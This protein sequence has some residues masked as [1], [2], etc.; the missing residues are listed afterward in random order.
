VTT[1]TTEQVIALKSMK[2]LAM[3]EEIETVLS[4]MSTI[5]MAVDAPYRKEAPSYCRRRHLD[6]ALRMHRDLAP[7]GPAGEPRRCRRTFHNVEFDLPVP[8]SRM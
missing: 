6:Q 4:R 7:A 3:S 2:A 8:P 5:C 1:A